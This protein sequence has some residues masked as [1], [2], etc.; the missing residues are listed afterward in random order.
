M[1]SCW[2]KGKNSNIPTFS[3][4]KLIVEKKNIK[5]PDAI[6]LLFDC[7]LFL[8]TGEHR[9]IMGRPRLPPSHP[10][11]RTHRPRLKN[12]P[13]LRSNRNR[14]RRNRR[15]LYKGLY[16]F[17]LLQSPSATINRNRAGRST[18]ARANGCPIG[19]VPSLPAAPRDARLLRITSRKK[20][21]TSSVSTK[22]PK[23]INSSDGSIGEKD[24]PQGIA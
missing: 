17:R 4:L 16:H 8:I 24:L 22:T 1:S 9:G 7:F 13:L 11:R 18:T 3:T 10:R 19:N 6:F 21:P 23:R 5:Q 20:R 14:R 15:R 12:N 2:K